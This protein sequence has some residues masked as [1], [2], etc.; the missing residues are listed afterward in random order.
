[1]LDTWS[2]NTWSNELELSDVFIHIFDLGEKLYV[3]KFTS[4][5][6]F[7]ETLTELYENRN[8]CLSVNEDCCHM[9]TA[10]CTPMLTRRK[11]MG[12]VQNTTTMFADD[13]VSYMPEFSLQRYEHNVEV[14]NS[15]VYLP[16]S[17]FL[18]PAEIC[19]NPHWNVGHDWRHL[20]RF[21]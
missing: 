6:N 5:E 4:Q 13:T 18:F 15:G 19:R 8:K 2:G 3:T 17:L 7:K 11:N 10:P 1:M 21:I 20:Q 9:K 16:R 12:I 14:W